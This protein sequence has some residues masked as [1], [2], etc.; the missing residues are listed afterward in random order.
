MGF[1][2]AHQ[3]HEQVEA[4]G[5]CICDAACLEFTQQARIAAINK[6]NIVGCNL[7]WVFS[8]SEKNIVDMS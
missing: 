5:H 3:L 2:D 1:E 7:F 6:D 4:W 8:G